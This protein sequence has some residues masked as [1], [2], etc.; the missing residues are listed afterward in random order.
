MYRWIVLA[1]VAV[2]SFWRGEPAWKDIVI[3]S[4]PRRTLACALT[5]SIFCTHPSCEGAADSLRTV[6]L[7][8][9]EAPGLAPGVSISSV[10][11]AWSLGNGLVGISGSL[12]GPGIL[13]S[14][15]QRNDFALWGESNAGLK[16]IVQ[17]GDIAS[18][19]TNGAVFGGRLIPLR[20][21]GTSAI[22]ADFVGGIG[23]QG[24]W[25]HSADGEL[26][27]V[28]FLG[29]R[30][31]GI[32]DDNIRIGRLTDYYAFPVANR[33]DQISFAGQYYGSGIVGGFSYGCWIRESDGQLR[34][35][36]RSGDPIPRMPAGFIM[37]G[38]FQDMQLSDSGRLAMTAD[39]RQYDSPDRV[40]GFRRHNALLSEHGSGTLA[41]IALQGQ[42]AP[43]VED[44]AVFDKFSSPWGEL[45]LNRFGKMIFG[46]TLAGGN[47]SELNVRGVWTDRTSN[48]LTLIARAGDRPPGS[49]AGTRWN[50]FGNLS[51]ND[52]D[53]IAFS[54]NYWTGDGAFGN[55]VWM[56]E[57]GRIELVAREGDLLP[58]L[59]AGAA[60]Y[61]GQVLRPND[62]PVALLDAWL[63]GTNINDGND[64]GL[65]ARNAVGEMLLVAREGDLLDV[66]DDPRAPDLR[67]ISFLGL[68]EIDELGYISFVAS[69]V[70]GTSGVFVS[71][72]VAVP[73]P[74]AVWL[75][76]LA[77]GLLTQ[78]RRPQIEGPQAT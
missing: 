37:D 1:M 54:A 60:F 20:E 8:G 18:G 16:K 36:T 50:G 23:G 31:P 43:G 12:S 46:A 9:D 55:G 3:R 13:T 39:I 10:A 67:R 72:L 21:G 65:W 27:S 15:P 48:G 78:C 17:R 4:R 29:D 47:A 56:E 76:T 62:R 5:L 19:T 73:E 49:S 77:L 57:Q 68:G 42:Q 38:R 32:S 22:W 30:A 44:G 61:F 41:V 33:R 59:S 25:H 14:G 35:V 70:D 53:E 34:I 45:A 7:S 64:R 66:S 26:E 11:G 24:I 2:G 51:I 74:S 63:T 58:G 71:S 40:G 69:F 75:A 52:H 6:T 28:I